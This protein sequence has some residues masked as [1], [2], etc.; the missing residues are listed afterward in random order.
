MNLQSNSGRISYTRT[1]WD[2]H[3][4]CDSFWVFYLE[5]KSIH[6]ERFIPR[7]KRKIREV[8]RYYNKINRPTKINADRIVKDKSTLPF[9]SVYTDKI[10]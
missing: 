10:D 9:A 1:V 2:S 7:F 6:S 5:A 3:L 4:C 8:G